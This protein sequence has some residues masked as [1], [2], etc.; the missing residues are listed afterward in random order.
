MQAEEPSAVQPIRSWAINTL[1]LLGIFYS[2]YLARELLLPIVLAVMLALLLAPVVLWLS[3]YRLPR[4][5][6]AALVAFGLAGVLLSVTGL[7]AQPAAQWA[8]KAPQLVS[9]LQVKLY[10]LTHKVEK[11]TKA[12]HRMEQMTSARNEGEDKRVVEIQGISLQNLLLKQ[13]RAFLVA[14]LVIFF[15]LYFLLAGADRLRRNTM[16]VL[17]D[18]RS[19]RRLMVV[20]RRLQ[21]EISRYLLTFAVINIVIGVLVVGLAAAFGLPNP[22][23]WGGIAALLNFVPYLGPMLTLTMLALVSLLSVAKIEI[24]MLVPLLFLVLTTIEGQLITPT[25]LGRSLALNPIFIF[26]GLI[27]WGWLWGILGALLA[28]PLMVSIKIVC[29]HVQS[30]QPF[31]RLLGD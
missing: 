6:S 28:V 14:L 8:Q 22:L 3:R 15:L 24:A 29:E 25:I 21:R 2:L 4:A 17:P 10:P 7:L 1:A 12:A 5:L 13:T 9:Q 20:T 31:A 18:Y 19:R 23:L 30:L 27:F 26:V 16:R 11:V